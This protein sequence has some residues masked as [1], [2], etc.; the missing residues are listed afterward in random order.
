MRNMLI[1]AYHY[2]VNNIILL[3][4]DTDDD[5]K[6]PTKA[7]ILLQMRLLIEN[8][9]LEELWFHYSG[10]GSQIQDERNPNEFD[11]I[12]VPLDYETEGYITTLDLANQIQ[13]IKCRAIMI[14]DS[15]HSGSI[16][17]LPWNF[18]YHTSTNL[19]RK[20][21]TFFISN[22]NIF[23]FSGCK[24][25]QTSADTYDKISDETVGAF[26]N[27]FITCLRKSN[28][29]I[30]IVQLYINICK[31]LMAMGYA[32]IPVLSSS[33]DTPNYILHRC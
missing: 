24:D 31:Y 2:D 1:D 12:I 13:N 21:N 27:A 4:D 3:R 8:D 19:F 32:Q 30:S 11:D 23:A 22:P 18:F 33:S 29:N 10:H 9:D 6:K 17:H 20:N 5:A 28:H 14:F 15:C 16:S 26:T 7:N 25:N